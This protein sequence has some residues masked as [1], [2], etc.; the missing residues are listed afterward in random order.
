MNPSKETVLKATTSQK[1]N[2]STKNKTHEPQSRE[3]G[4]MTAAAVQGGGKTRQNMILISGYVKDKI[5]TKVKGRP[6]LILDPNGE[7]TKAEFMKAGLSIEAKTIAV[8]DVKDW[9]RSGNVEVRR[10]DMKSLTP[11]QML[12]IL[13]YVIQVVKDCLLVIE[14]INTMTLD[15]TH[16]KAI[17]QNIVKLR[18]KGVDV[19]TSYQSLRAVEPRILQNS[20]FLR[21]HF[22]L[23]S[24]DDIHGKLPCD[25]EVFK[26]AQII[27]NTKRYAGDE[28]FFLYI[29]T[30]KGFIKGNF[31]KKDFM[32]ACEVYLLDESKKI[33][34]E[35]RIRKCSETEAIASQSNI[36][37][38]QFYG[39]DDKEN[40]NIPPQKLLT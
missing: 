11:D 23:G 26:I 29:Y 35:M 36:L 32:D 28:Y 20:R 19:L 10:I 18:H 40:S 30:M 27:V 34:S 13:Q 38:K 8:K 1:N 25:V 37:Y 17:V 21:L 3:A 22:Q 9:V 12:M 5:A 15:V 31:S 4:L 33:K 14:D 16:A 2:M 39:N 24:V 7:Y 6:V